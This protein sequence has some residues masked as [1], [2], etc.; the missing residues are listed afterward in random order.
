MIIREA[1]SDDGFAIARVNVES[2]R[3]TYRGLLPD[4][5]LAALSVEERALG[6]LR[7]LQNPEPPSFTCVVEMDGRVV[8]F[9]AGGAER[10]GDPI[11]KG[12]VYAIY[13]LPAYQRRGIGS[14]LLREGA[15]RLVQSG[16]EA[17]LVWMLVGNPSSRF[18]EAMG[19]QPLRTEPFRILGVMR[20]KIAYG[21]ADIRALGCGAKGTL[22]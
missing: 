17:M 3:A 13:L 4:E 20:E 7:R 14:A 10:E 21:W 1:R 8:G 12:E 2:W 22:V 15:S 9:V 6:W 19:G 11:Y 5:A 18:Y 16:F